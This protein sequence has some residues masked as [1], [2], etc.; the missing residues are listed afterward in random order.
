MT[1]CEEVKLKED[2]KTIVNRMTILD[3]VK[4]IIGEISDIHPMDVASDQELGKISSNDAFIQQLRE[5]FSVE[6]KKE[7]I[8]EST[9][10]LNLCIL[11]EELQKK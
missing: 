6:I 2:I 11:I 4:K 1:S 10:V 5:S 8:S 7:L 9:T 3:K